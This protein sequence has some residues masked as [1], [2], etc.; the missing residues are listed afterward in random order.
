MHSPKTTAKKRSVQTL[1][2]RVFALMAIV[3]CLSLISGGIALY[4]MSAEAAPTAT[5]SV[6]PSSGAQQVGQNFVV[7]LKL[8]TGGQAVAGVNV[9]VAFSSNLIFVTSSSTNSVFDQDVILPT[10]AGNTVQFSRVRFDAGYNGTNGQV[11][12]LTFRMTTCGTAT[13]SIDKTKSEVTAYS[14]SSD[15]LQ[16]TVNGSYTAPCTNTSSSSSAPASA[17]SAASSVASSST[18]PVD[19]CNHNGRCDGLESCG[20]CPGE[21]CVSTPITP[22]ASS[23]SQSRVS[24]SQ[25]THPAAPASSEDA[26]PGVTPSVGDPQVSGQMC[27]LSKSAVTYTPAGATL[28][29]N[30]LTVSD[31]PSDAW[32]ARYVSALMRMNI[33][34]GY[35]DASGTPLGKFGPGNAITLAETLKIAIV[36]NGYDVSQVTATSTNAN[37]RNQWFEK[38]VLAAQASVWPIGQ[39]NNFSASATR[40]VFVDTLLRALGVHIDGPTQCG[41]TDMAPDNPYARSICTAVQHG[42][43][44]GY[45]DK[46]GKIGPNNPVNRAEAVKMLDIGFNGL[47]T[48]QS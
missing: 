12:Q 47:A 48:C 34:S 23:S 31:V 14:D 45:A 39:A 7:D 22:T 15:S 35:R 19:I 46:P 2:N 27:D 33:V 13:V 30:G 41:F 4:L 42:I 20:T 28:V 37:V 43:M 1:S 29:V 38:Y 44:S 26:T 17:A 18:A 5:L 11:M 21:C 3:S 36:A 9:N 6:V 25:R 16:T 32:Y 8:T 24:S 10:M 40:G